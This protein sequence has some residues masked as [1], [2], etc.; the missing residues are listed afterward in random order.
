[1]YYLKG[2]LQYCLLAI[3]I[4]AVV[5]IYGQCTSKPLPRTILIAD[6]VVEK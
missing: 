4:A 5:V 2:V 6:P 3:L 1:M